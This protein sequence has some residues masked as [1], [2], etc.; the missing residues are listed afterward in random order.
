MR[1]LLV[2]CGDP[3]PAV[4]ET[5]GCYARWFR[6]ALDP[7][8]SLTVVDA[9]REGPTAR[10]LEGVGAVLVSGSPESVYDPLPWVP[11]W[12]GFVRE[13]VC[14]RGV[15]FL[16]VCFGHQLLAH[17]LGGEVTRNPLGREMGTVSLELTER[18]RGSALFRGITGVPR[19]QVTHRDTVLRP[20][21]GAELL[22]VSAGDRCQAFRVG[23]AYGVQ[24]HPEVTAA[25]L[26]SYVES[27]RAVLRAE[28]LDPD[29]VSASIETASD[30]PRVLGNFVR[31]AFGR[32]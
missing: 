16:G 29:A 18:G 20:P 8:V 28:G 30:G 31:E 17:A 15:A 21:P 24:F 14:A 1:C 2:R 9:R 22:A 11:A 5:H 10:H 25:V 32:G 23:T 12:A 27:R 19:V 3:D 7:T 4:E 6:E 26:R 13:V